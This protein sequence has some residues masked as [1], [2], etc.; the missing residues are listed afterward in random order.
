[1][2]NQDPEQIAR[3]NIDRQLAGCGWVLQ[4][5][6]GMN[7][8]AALGVAVRKYYTQEGKQLDYALFVNGKPV[9]VIE[10]KAEEKGFQ[11]IHAESQ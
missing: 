9:G 8:K 2:V 10:A 3:D 4:D 6:A 11:L 5:K 1:M 7:L